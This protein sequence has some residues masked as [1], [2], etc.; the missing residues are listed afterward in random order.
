MHEVQPEL[1]LQQ[2][3]R[4][5]RL[6]AVARRGEVERAG[7]R[8]R[9]RDQFLDRPR[10]HVGMDDEHVLHGGDPRDR[11]EILEH[12][13]RE[14][15]VHVRI[16]NQIAVRRGKKRVAVRGRFCA[17]FHAEVARGARPVFD[18]YRLAPDR[19]E[20]FA[21]KSR[22]EIGRAAWR[23]RDDHAHGFL[24]PGLGLGECACKDKGE[25][26]E[27]SDHRWPVGE[28]H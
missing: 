19:A 3:D 23:E 21:D 4:D 7:L 2:L 6:A 12:V 13:V 9:K 28:G 26:D 11:R 22:H 20:L 24:R 10:G 17:G 5:V 27:Q 8:L 1:Q 25:G 15:R 18:Y 14:L 16:D